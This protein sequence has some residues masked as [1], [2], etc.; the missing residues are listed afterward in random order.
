MG[1][2]YVGIYGDQWS[3]PDKQLPLVS[4]YR[5]DKDGFVENF[6]MIGNK[7]VQY[8]KMETTIIP[9]IRYVMYKNLR[10]M[11]RKIEDLVFSEFFK[12]YKS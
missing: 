1:H 10:D 2:H 9:I 4:Y 12:Y 3:V 5:K 8:F 6:K 7:V 11:K